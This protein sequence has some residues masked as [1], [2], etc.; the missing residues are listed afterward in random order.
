MI[1][2]LLMISFLLENVLSIIIP[3]N[4]LFI[5]MFSVIALATTYPLF[6][7]NRIKY[8]IYA[9]SF[10]LL[11]DI[12]YT[13]TPFINTISFLAVAYIITLIYEYIRVSK[14][15]ILLINLVVILFYQTI[16]YLLL[17]AVRYSTF[18]ETTFIENLY[19]SLILNLIYGLILYIILEIINKKR[20]KI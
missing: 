12:V 20:K 14:F 11:Y 6:K 2:L 3:P 10:G 9:S 18:N 19:S 7:D 1:I 8:L 17:C 16:S 15:N 5:P 4:T 13:N